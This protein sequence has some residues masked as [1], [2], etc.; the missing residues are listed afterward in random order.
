MAD[1]LLSEEKLTQLT[2]MLVQFL[3][4]FIK[5][6]L[7][8]KITHAG[9]D[10]YMNKYTSQSMIGFPLSSHLTGQS[11]ENNLPKTSKGYGMDFLGSSL[12]RHSKLALE[13]N[14]YFF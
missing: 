2:T 10:F 12:I 13:A 5:K 4:F 3:L 1:L 11:L 8:S 7:C 14:T 6:L 9:F